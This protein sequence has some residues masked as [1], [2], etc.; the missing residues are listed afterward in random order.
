MKGLP[1]GYAH[2][3]AQVDVTPLYTYKYIVCCYINAGNLN[4]AP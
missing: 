2:N 3:T 1:L 4:I